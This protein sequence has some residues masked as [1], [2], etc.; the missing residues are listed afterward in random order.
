VPRV[1]DCSGSSRIAKHYK[2]TSKR[3]TLEAPFSGLFLCVFAGGTTSGKPDPVDLCG[4]FVVGARPNL[5][6]IVMINS[7]INKMVKYI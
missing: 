2:N 7:G 1:R 3:A 4:G 6:F 5:N